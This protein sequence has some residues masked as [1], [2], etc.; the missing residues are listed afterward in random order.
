[1]ASDR[2]RC[3]TLVSSAKHATPQG[4]GWTSR[5]QPG[6]REPWVLKEVSERSRERKNAHAKVRTQ[7]RSATSGTVDKEPPGNKASVIHPSEGQTTSGRDVARRHSLARGSDGR[8]VRQRT[9]PSGQQALLGR[10]TD[11]AKS[12]GE[13]PGGPRKR[14]SEHLGASPGAHFGPEATASSCV[15]LEKS[16]AKAQG[17]PR[18]SGAKDHER[19]AER[20]VNLSLRRCEAEYLKDQDIASQ[21]RRGRGNP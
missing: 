2:G 11:T 1:L 17:D 18:R 4:A 9:S 15:S 16:K 5:S 21:G 7:D 3:A 14:A 8:A 13:N 12:S 20:G 6:A 10:T 19:L